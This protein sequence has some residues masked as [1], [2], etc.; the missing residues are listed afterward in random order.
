MVEKCDR[1]MG[2][3]GGGGGN[4]GQKGLSSEGRKDLSDG[5]GW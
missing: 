1:K 3:D 2:G 5:R 4:E